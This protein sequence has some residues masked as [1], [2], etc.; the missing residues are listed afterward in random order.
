MMNKQN[1]SVIFLIFNK[2]ILILF[3]GYYS[4]RFFMIKKVCFISFCVATVT[5]CVQHKEKVLYEELT[6]REFRARLEACPVAYLPLGTLEWHGEHLPLGSD[7]LQSLEFFKRLATEAGG[8]V[9]PMLFVGPDG[10][11]TII[12]G[13]E[14][15]GMD[16]GV[17]AQPSYPVQQ[18][19][20]S[21]YHVPDSVFDMLINHIMKQLAR[22]G[23]KIVVAHGHGPSGVYIEEH[24]QWFKEKYHLTVMTCWGKDTFLTPTTH[25]CLQCDHAAAN[26]TSMM[27]YVRPDL[28]KMENLPAD[29]HQWPLAVAGDDPRLYASR[30]YG[31]KICE[32]ELQKMKAIINKELHHR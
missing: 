19:T 11:D 16:N 31:K 26:E 25:L 13:K 28:V 9:L 7:G 6:P 20:G 2:K 10:R 14:Y 8:I 15:Y 12:D 1:K 24:K 18:L 29:T 22:A 5:A 17:H 32:Y 21:A 4:K 23:F 3:V 27:M 30:E